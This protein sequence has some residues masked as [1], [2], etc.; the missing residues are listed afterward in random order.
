MFARHPSKVALRH[1][2]TVARGD[3]PA[4]RSL[5]KNDL[6]KVRRGASVVDLLW[7]WPAL[8]RS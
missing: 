6:A 1:V 2:L 8:L 5:A 4:R 3:A 7:F